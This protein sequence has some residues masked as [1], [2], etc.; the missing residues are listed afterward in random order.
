V[1]AGWNPIR[2]YS[3]RSHYQRGG[4]GELSDLLR[5]YWKDAPFSDDQRKQMYGLSAEDFCLVDC[6]ADADLAVLPMT[7]NHYVRTGLVAHAL[8]FVREARRA[9]RPV[10][11]YVSG[12]QGIT[13]PAGCED[14]YV[15]RASGAR[16]RK[17]DRQI[18]QPVFFD[19]PVV[20]YPDLERYGRPDEA[21]KIASVGFCGQAS[22][23]P[24]KLAADVFRGGFRAIQYHLGIRLE[25]PQPLYPPALLR[26]RAMKALE[27]SPLVQTRFIAR[28]RYRG[29][30]TSAETRQQTS[31]DFYQNIA[32]T[33]Y[34]LCVRGGGNFSKRFYETLAMGRIPVLLDTDCLLPF[35][36]SLLWAD[37]I[38]RVPQANWHALPRAVATHFARH[39]GEALAAL[40]RRCRKLWEE[41][42]SFG[43]FHRELVRIVLGHSVPEAGRLRDASTS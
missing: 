1:T 22:V 25:E 13:V 30:A 20:D 42:L 35:E 38:V 10:L 34:T 11:S 16:S 27:S 15:V 32:E 4:R 6:L 12:D 9:G 23:N 2:L 5:P 29:G 31:R 37:F 21:V 19:D 33:D 8:D 39:P 36:P 18:A 7:W 17:R 28:R 40:K 3:D 41:R 24:L 26:A 14:V 43:G